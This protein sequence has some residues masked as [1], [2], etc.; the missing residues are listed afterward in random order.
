MSQRLGFT[1]FEV[2]AS[3]ALIAVAVT[4]VLMLF[5]VGL[6]TQLHS[7]Y[8]LYAAVKAEEMAEAFLQGDT[9][10]AYTDTETPAPWDAPI[11]YRS[12]AP[13]LECKL[14]S[15]R[16]GVW[17]VPDAIARRIDSDGDVI[18]RLLDDGAQLSYSQPLSTTGE[19][20]WVWGANNWASGGNAIAM[21]NESQKLVF[22]VVGS[23]QHNALPTLPAKR[24]PYYSAY[25]SPPLHINRRGGMHMPAWGKMVPNWPR[26]N[27]WPLFAWEA[28]APGTPQPGTDPDIA[29]V[30]DAYLRPGTASQSYTGVL[31][32]YTG[33]SPSLTALTEAGALTYLQAALWYCER[34]GLTPAFY[35]PAVLDGTL[36]FD[37]SPEE[38][39]QVQGMRFLA[40]AAACMTRW[41]TLAQLGGQ[42]ST[43]PGYAVPSATP[44]G[45][46][47]PS[48]AYTL[49][50]DKITYLH[51]RCLRLACA[52]A[53]RYPYDW[54]VPRPINRAQMM[55]FP[56]IEYDLFSP[57]R[58]GLQF[59]QGADTAAQWRPLPASPISNPGVGMMFPDQ[60]MN[61]IPDAGVRISNPAQYRAIW[62]PRD[63][64]GPG[65]SDHVTLTA[66]FE[67]AER[68]RMIVF[69][70]VDWMSYEDVET[71]PSAAIDASKF[72]FLAPLTRWQGATEIPLE[73]RER[74][75]RQF[76]A[77]QMDPPFCNPERWNIWMND[78]RLA[79]TG[80]AGE[81]RAMTALTNSIGDLDWDTAAC[82]RF[83]GVYGAD[84]NL[85]RVLD[86]GPTPR[87]ARMRAIEVARFL[88]YDPRVPVMLR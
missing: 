73:K 40:H 83:S 61:P 42:P 26:G 84:R 57:P 79:G 41:K 66:P 45:A 63:L 54:S 74:M 15:T 76:T 71:A 30:M 39:K 38:W 28:S 8:Q 31:S 4:S 7:R 75:K 21:P 10:S 67:P 34:K 32:T 86:R 68:T 49:T 23:P 22:A 36:D 18:K 24:W 1:L 20:T 64:P 80:I 27:Q 81:T 85:N 48:P 78:M 53:S 5:P 3:L 6:K 14:S 44:F 72:P 58:T 29:V 69:W 50:H 55:D 19:A 65:P 59:N 62:A 13:D 87:S 51:E 82:K 88:Y 9:F 16:Y 43:G 60:A 35:D 46:S 2:A 37:A 17:P 12:Q 47:T 77:F 25:P 56:L 70:A 11:G 33:M 52:F